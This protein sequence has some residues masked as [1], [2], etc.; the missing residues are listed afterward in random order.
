MQNKSRKDIVSINLRQRATHN[1]RQSNQKNNSFHPVRFMHCRLEIFKVAKV[2]TVDQIFVLNHS[3]ALKGWTPGSAL[4]QTKAIFAALNAIPDV[5]RSYRSETIRLNRQYC[6][7]WLT[8]CRHILI[9]AKHQLAAVDKVLF[10]LIL[11]RVHK[12]SAW[13][14]LDW[15]L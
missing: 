7:Q 15:G 8:L 4:F 14:L 13:R 11:V 12:E 2:F 1:H 10:F 6:A 9:P 5:S 3:T